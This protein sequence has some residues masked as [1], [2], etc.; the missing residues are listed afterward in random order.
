MKHSC[1]C[2]QVSYLLGCHYDGEENALFGFGGSIT[3]TVY[4]YKMNPHPQDGM[5]T[6]IFNAPT[7]RF[8]GGHKD[9][10][11]SIAFGSKN[12][13]LR[14]SLCITGGDDGHLCCWA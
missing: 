6:N 3:G 10:V 9:T 1:L 4:A 14:V 2:H 5:H 12:R 7:G 8:V 13:V 11:R